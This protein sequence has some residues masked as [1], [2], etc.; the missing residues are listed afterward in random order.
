MENLFEI[1]PYLGYYHEKCEKFVDKDLFES[2]YQ[3][4]IKLTK[5]KLWYGT[6]CRDSDYNENIFGRAILGIQSDYVNPLNGEK[7]QTKMYCGKLTSNDIITKDLELNDGDY[8]TKFYICYNDIITYIKF[9]TKKEKILEIGNYDKDCAKTISFNNDETPH[10]IQSFHGRFNDY[11]LRALGCVHVK[12]KNYFFL[13]LIDVFRYRHL[14]KNN[15]KERDK[16]TEDKIKSLNTEE[17]AFI[18]LCLLPDS[19]FYCVIKFC[20]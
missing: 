15:Q 20:C 16:W 18:N 1:I 17:K 2:Q 3:N 8:I 4:Y 14:M 7:K 11:G 9:I 12:R 5:V 13:N 10:M 6:C 19:Q